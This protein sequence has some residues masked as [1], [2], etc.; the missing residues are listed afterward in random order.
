[1][2]GGNGSSAVRQSSRPKTSP[3]RT[4]G[5]S[6]RGYAET[7]VRTFLRRVSE[8]L[9]AAREREEQLVQAVDELEEELRAP[10]PLDEQQLLDALGEETARLLRTAREASDDIRRKAEE[11]SSSVMEEAQAEA[12]RLRTE[13]AE[14]L[15]VRTAEAESAAADIVGEAEARGAELRAANDRAAEDQ[16][17]RAEQE[18]GSIVESARLQ[19][20]EMLDEARVAR[21]RVLA[22]LG[23]RRSLLQAQVEELRQ[24][25]D[26]LLEAYRVVKRTFL[27]AT[28]ALAHV[29]ARAASERAL[30]PGPDNIAGEITVTESETEILEVVEVVL[31]DAG[32]ATDADDAGAATDATADAAAPSD[33]G[34]VDSLFARIR[35][36]QTAPPDEADADTLL[37]S[38]PLRAR[39][40]ARVRGRIRDRGHR[41]RGH[42]DCGRGR[43]GRRR[44]G[45]HG[46][47]FRGRC[48]AGAARRSGRSR[49]SARS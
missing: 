10:R 13:A 14:I 27:D 19:G 37:P 46:T 39:G 28:E 34:H 3:T 47:R 12:H 29:E 4:F 41:H 22:D 42:R 32:T 5:S 1:M 7:E 36:G 21:E 24:G 23:R 40:D 8:D 38:P 20:R 9:T 15:S 44:P 45:G 11:R 48:V 49:W 33:L 25:R 26:R 2:T 43:P 6:F 18:A 16:R 30:A 31:P 17:L 35:A